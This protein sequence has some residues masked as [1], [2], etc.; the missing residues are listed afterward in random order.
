M[1]VKGI[2]LPLGYSCNNN[3]IHCFLPFADNPTNRTTEQVKEAIRKA[4]D[5][6]VDRISLTGGEPTIRKDIFELVSFCRKLGIG[7]IQV[8][9]NA[10]MLSYRPFCRRLFSSGLTEVFVSF[11]GHTPAIQ[12]SITRVKGSFEQTLAGVRNLMEVSRQFIE[13][14]SIYANL[15]ISKYNYRHLADIVRF[16]SKLG[17]PLVEIEYPRMAGNAWKFRD[18]MPSRPEA[19]EHMK[20]AAETA[21]SIGMNVFIDDFPVCFSDGFY[22]F[23]AYTRSGNKQVELDFSG[24][25]IKDKEK[26]DKIHGAKCKSCLARSI[27]P[28]EWPE[29]VKFLGWNDFKPVSKSEMDSILKVRNARG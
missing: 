4:V 1:V 10:R 18:L 24:D 16:F 12:D 6:G 14:D 19:A 11:H 3:C 5:Y 25:R 28:G 9:T 21:R 20:A 8:Q 29:N 22:D 2:F 27:C 17:F 23:N 7:M 13:G 26:M 15:V